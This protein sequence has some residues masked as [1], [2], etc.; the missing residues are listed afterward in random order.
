M[1]TQS[2]HNSGNHYK[3]SNEHSASLR[4]A[5]LVAALYLVFMTPLLGR[6]LGYT[7]DATP[8]F[9]LTRVIVSEGTLFPDVKVKQGW[10]YS[11]AYLP[12]YGLGTL[13]HATVFSSQP[14][15]WVQRKCMCWM[16]MVFAAMTL[17][18]IART[19][20]RLG[21]SGP[22]NAEPRCS[23]ASRRWG[24]RTRVMTTTKRWRGCC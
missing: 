2:A 10:L 12:F 19:L 5:L 24:F 17:G 3:I 16:N 13:L 18:L 4:L 7:V 8:S 11:I 1:K 14:L 23:T 21:Y 15:D 9:Q 6:K 22:R 20:G